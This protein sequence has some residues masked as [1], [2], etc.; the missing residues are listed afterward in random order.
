MLAVGGERLLE[1]KRNARNVRA[2]LARGGRIVE[3]DGYGAIV[4][5]H[6][7]WFPAM[8]AEWFL[9]PWAGFHAL[10]V[11]LLAAFLLADALRYWCMLTLRER[12]TT[13]VVVLPDAPLVRE[14]PYR[15]LSHPI[16]LAVA[17]LVVAFPA[18]FGLFATAVLLGAAN[19]VA[20][21]R[22]IRK[23]ERALAA[24]SRGPSARAA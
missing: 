17:V 7:L 18:A 22:R 6:A 5:V 2:L 19:L 13:K 24:A 16:Y 21:Q 9:A 3:D 10:T 11:P 1:L 8:L 12:W 20:V 4:A 14:G 15:Y 23:E